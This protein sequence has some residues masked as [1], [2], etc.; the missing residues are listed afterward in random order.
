MFKIYIDGSCRGNGGPDSI[1]GIGVAIYR[2]DKL[3]GSLALRMFQPA[4]NNEAE[5]YA[6]LR[7]MTLVPKN[8]EVL[9]YSDSK[10]VVN[11]VN[12]KW[13]AKEARLNR[14]KEK[15]QELL[16]Q[17]TKVTLKWVP[18]TQ[19]KLANKLAQDITYETK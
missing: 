5:Y 4:T 7:A 19:N 9:I 15:A 3:V 2:D 1:G 16:K 10:L 8:D 6:L 17:F 11:Q 18:R 14:L 13:K 12:G